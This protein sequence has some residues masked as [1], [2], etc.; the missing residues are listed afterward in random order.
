MTVIALVAV[1][2][3]VAK[4]VLRLPIKVPGHAGVLWI[5]AML[6]GRAAVRRPGSATLMGLVGGTLVAFL[7]PSDAGI[8]FAVAKYVLPGIVIDLL[9]PL[10]GDH[11]ERIPYAMVVGAAAHASKV[12]VDTA[13]SLVAG[14]TGP[15][16][17]AGLTTTLLL[18]I[19]FGALGGLLAALLLKSLIKAGVPQLAPLAQGGELA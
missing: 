3:V 19:A 18:H 13:Q 6:V 11:L 7:S 17:V 16:L 8:L 4:A 1:M 10:F 2:I 9:S 15:L 14:V 5:A 12:L